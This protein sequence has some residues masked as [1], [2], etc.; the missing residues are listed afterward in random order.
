MADDERIV[1]AQRIHPKDFSWRLWPVLPLYPYGRRQTIRKEVVKD[2]IWN[3]DQI[4][5][6]FYVVV[7]IRMT[8]VKL[9][10]GGLLIYAPVAPTP[11]CIRLVNELVVEH[12]SVKYIILPTI[13]GIEHKVFVGPFARYFPTAQ[14][15]VAPHQWSFPLN[16]PLSWL[17]LPRK[18]TQ[19]LPEDSS[20]TPF[21]DEFDYAMLGPIELGPGRFAEVAFF[22]KRSHTLLVTDS[23]LSIPEDPPAIVLLDPYPLLFHAKDRASDIVADIQVNRRKGWQRICLFALYFQPSALHIPQWSQVL[24]DAFKAPERSR[25][26]YFGL[27]PFT[28][29]PDWLRSFDA[30]RGNGRLF[31]APILQ[32]LI[33]NRAPKETIE[34]ADKVASWNFQWIIP[35]HFDSPIKAEPHQFRQAFSFLEKQSAVNEGLFSSSSYP[36]PEVDFQTLREIDAGLNKFGIV[37]AAK[38]KV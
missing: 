35:C 27:Y 22:H 32:T 36:L 24:Q 11:E 16:L 2:T 23:V 7:P 17:G 1:N 34:W 37:P 10:T 18:R 3:F 38:E 21:A 8:V 26:A 14:V 15:F 6:I 5:G 13:S 19:V 28:W 30:L 33:L 29:H 9:E 25:K 12:G 20:K 31:V 4:Q